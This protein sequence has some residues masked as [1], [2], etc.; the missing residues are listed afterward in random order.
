MPKTVE[1]NVHPH[2]AQQSLAD[3][4]LE[5]GHCADAYLV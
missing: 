1:E 2:K 4:N 5:D 3:H